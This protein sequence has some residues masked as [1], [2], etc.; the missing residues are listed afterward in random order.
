MRTLDAAH[1]RLNRSLRCRYPLQS[2]CP[3]HRCLL[4]VVHARP[5]ALLAA[6][7]TD[8]N[9]RR[10]GA[11]LAGLEQRDVAAFLVA[12]FNEQPDCPFQ[13][14]VFHG[15][16]SWQVMDR[17]GYVESEATSPIRAHQAFVVFDEARCRCADFCRICHNRTSLSSTWLDPCASSL[18][19]ATCRPDVLSLFLPSEVLTA[20]SVMISGGSRCP[21]HRARA[22][23]RTR[24]CAAMRLPQ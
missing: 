2:D 13:G 22:G 11:L 8:L 7:F 23:A 6:R 9:A 21:E 19:I 1:P 3:S 5:R 17:A 24:N 20:T 12:R 15:A 4:G 14:V 16:A 18:A 10:A